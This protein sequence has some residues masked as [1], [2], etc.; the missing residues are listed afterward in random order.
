MNICI[1][2]KKYFVKNISSFKSDFR[3]YYL[4]E[5]YKTLTLL[6]SIMGS[7]VHINTLGEMF[8]LSIQDLKDDF[9]TF[10]HEISKSNNNES[11]WGT[12]LASKNSAAIDL[13]RDLVY[14]VCGK[15][16]INNSIND[17]INEIVI[18]YDSYS[19]GKTLY[20]EVKQD[21]F[22]TK[23]KATFHCL[24]EDKF[25]LIKL[26]I[27]IFVHSCFFILRSL[28]IWFYVRIVHNKYHKKKIIRHGCGMKKT[29]V[30]SW[31]STGSFDKTGKYI[32]RN[33]GHLFQYAVP[34]DGELW[35]YPM[36]FNLPHSMF[37]QLK[38]NAKS[39]M[40]FITAEEYLPI[41]GCF[42]TLARGLKS[43]FL[44]NSRNYSF[45]GLNDVKLII[46]YAHIKSSLSYQL[47]EN[48]MQFELMKFFSE[49]KIK[50]DKVLYSFENNV[51][52]KLLIRSVRKYLQNTKLVGFQHC[53][54]FT[55]Q[56]GMYLSKD[57]WKV[58]PLPDK[59]ISGG[60]KLIEVLKDANFPAQILALGPSLRFQNIATFSYKET[61]LTKEKSILILLNFD[62]NQDLE[63]LDKIN[64]SMQQLA[65]NFKDDFN[66][67]LPV[68][69]KLRPHP[70]TNMK[71]IC[72]YLKIINFPAY[73]ICSG[74]GVYDAVSKS[75]VVV[76]TLGSVSNLEVI[77]FGTPIVRISLDNNFNFDP[78]WEK[79]PLFDNPKNAN[80]IYNCLLKAL[81]L[82]LNSKKSLIEFGKL[83]QNNYFE[84]IN[85]NNIRIFFE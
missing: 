77:V 42:I 46:K 2:S 26:W 44:N 63:M 50:I 40:N 20:K 60:R 64:F 62:L 36:Y 47:L 71:E 17:D 51:S 55:E 5:D 61:N 31:V 78:L 57:D 65:I 48:N 15:T 1:V 39:N 19:V 82:D 54:W 24:L 74:G 32:D 13:L 10:C 22:K 59:I 12:H 33:F 30:R 7:A 6:R 67:R 79:Y 84:Q 28:T 72:N 76:M 3:F 75:D 16:I 66:N 25:S 68:K 45:A 56:L 35:F 43:L 21:D 73:E 38:I 69:I 41:W 53:V 8:H 11:Y 37:R 9:L 85:E 52:E 34:S 23:I 58:H 27:K 70:L 18:V 80:E 49:K 14:C 81:S 83:V 29:I 4:S